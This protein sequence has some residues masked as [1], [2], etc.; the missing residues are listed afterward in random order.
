MNKQIIMKFSLNVDNEARNRSEGQVAE[1][2]RDRYGLVY[3]PLNELQAHF[4]AVARIIGLWTEAA[5]EN[6]WNLT[7]VT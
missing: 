1:A 2:I 5:V 7:T 4:S 3:F 6:A